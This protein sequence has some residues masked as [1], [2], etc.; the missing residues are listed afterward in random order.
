MFYISYRWNSGKV[1][2]EFGTIKLARH[3]EALK[4]FKRLESYRLPLWIRAYLKIE[5][6][7]KFYWNYR[8]SMIPTRLIL[9]KRRSLE[10]ICKT[11]A[12]VAKRN[13]RYAVCARLETLA[14]WFRYPYAR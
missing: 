9:F 12:E 5:D 7:V 11:L 14:H 3:C 4:V 1:G 13:N 2:R 6:V 10:S 8:I